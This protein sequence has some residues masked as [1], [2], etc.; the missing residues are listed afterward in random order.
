MGNVWKLLHVLSGFWFVAGLVGRT[1]TIGQARRESDVGRIEALMGAAGRFEKLMVIPGSAAVLV[2]GLVT[3]VAQGRSLLGEGERWLL[4]ALVL[5]L[6][7]MALVPTIL[8]PRGKAFEVAFEE[9]KGAGEVTPAL[10]AA[11]ADPMVALARRAE[12]V[13]VAV[14]I[15]LMV[16]KPF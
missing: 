5:Y 4:T 6:A 15:G 13:L 16:L 2:L 7:V 10:T 9:A 12:L 1:A 14:V 11:F 8:L 3:M